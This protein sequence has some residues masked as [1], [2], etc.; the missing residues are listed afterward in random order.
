MISVALWDRINVTEMA[1]IIPFKL[2]RDGLLI[3]LSMIFMVSEPYS[4]SM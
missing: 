2:N 4:Y 1:Y 3:T